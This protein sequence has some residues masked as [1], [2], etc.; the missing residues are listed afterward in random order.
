VPVNPII[1]TRTRCYRHAYPR[2][3]DSIVA[4]EHTIRLPYDYI[5]NIVPE[6]RCDADRAVNS[7]LLQSSR[8]TRV[9]DGA[10]AC[11]E[12]VVERSKLT[13]RSELATH[14]LN[15]AVRKH[16]RVTVQFPWL[17]SV[18]S[19]CNNFVC[20]YNFLYWKNTSLIFLLTLHVSA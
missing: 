13:S 11:G 6:M 4:T 3:R 12:T 1:R 5:G 9:E 18:P 10:A 19:E 15:L 17:G 16:D 2:I 8:K 14:S 7:K 20:F